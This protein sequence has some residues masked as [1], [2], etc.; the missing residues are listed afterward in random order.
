MKERPWRELFS[1]TSRNFSSGCI[2]V[3]NPLDL[4]EYLLADQPTW[5]RAEIDRAVAGGVE[6]TVRLS[7]AVPVHLLYWT[8]WATSDGTVHFRPDIYGR[9][10]TVRTALQAEPPGT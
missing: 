3:E 10:T 4:A 1:R 9:D 7:R 2:R 6:R 5:T 8:A